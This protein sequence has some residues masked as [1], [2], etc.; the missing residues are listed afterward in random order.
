MGNRTG[1]FALAAAVSL[2]FGSAA[3]AQEPA[4]PGSQGSSQAAD[5]LRRAADE[6]NEAAEALRSEIGRAHV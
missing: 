4:Q 1:A 3:L 6:L 2:A 5:A